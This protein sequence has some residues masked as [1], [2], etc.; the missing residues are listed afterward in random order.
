MNIRA[1]LLL[2]ANVL[3]WAIVINLWSIGGKQESCEAKGGVLA[4]V[5]GNKLCLQKP[6]TILQ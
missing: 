6:L 3:M 1:T 2:I 4:E 5:D